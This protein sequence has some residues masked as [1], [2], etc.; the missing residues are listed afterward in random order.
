M[1]FISIYKAQDIGNN[2]IEDARI[3]IECALPEIKGDNWLQVTENIYKSEAE[4]LNKTL[5]NSLPGGTYDQL[6]IEMLKT[7]ASHFKVPW[8]GDK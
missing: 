7:K 1:K 6:L 2:K 3:M 4:L 8:G 5:L